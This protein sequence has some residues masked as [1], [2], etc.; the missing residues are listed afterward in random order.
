MDGRTG[1]KTQTQSLSMLYATL[2]GIKT[3][4]SKA[5]E[6]AIDEWVESCPL[7]RRS[8]CSHAVTVRNGRELDRQFD[9]IW[10]ELA[11]DRQA[12]RYSRML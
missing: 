5:I 1:I 7:K 10:N 4:A 11:N 3:M 6:K 12:E 8:L 2:L 9:R